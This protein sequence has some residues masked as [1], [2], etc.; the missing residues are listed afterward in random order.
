M[1]TPTD[2]HFGA[3]PSEV[4]GSAGLMACDRLATLF[5][6]YHDD[7]GQ[8]SPEAIRALVAKIDALTAEAAQLL[9]PPRQTPPPEVVACSAYMAAQR[10]ERETRP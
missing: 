6:R 2:S 8:A 4:E 7:W 1:P 9:G 10:A 3:S 5:D